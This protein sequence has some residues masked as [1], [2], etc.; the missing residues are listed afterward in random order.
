MLGFTPLSRRLP[1]IAHILQPVFAL[2]ASH[3]ADAADDR[4]ADTPKTDELEDA[5][6]QTSQTVTRKYQR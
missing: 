2:G 1:E 4:R 5:P 3:V 6:L